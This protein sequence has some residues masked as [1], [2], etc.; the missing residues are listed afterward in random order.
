MNSSCAST[1]RSP[2]ARLCWTGFLLITPAVARTIPAAPEDQ[3]E[4]GVPPLVI[5][6]REAVGLSSEPTD[7]HL[8]S[9][10][11]LLV[12]GAAE[13]AIGD[14][15]RWEVIRAES[16]TPG[17]A[18]AT[19]AVDYEDRIYTGV[20]DGFA[21]VDFTPSGN[22]QLTRVADWPTELLGRMPVPRIV[23]NVAGRWFWH[24]QSGVV[25]EWRPGEEA[26]AFAQAST[27]EDIFTHNGIYYLSDRVVGRL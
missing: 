21:R 4:L 26:Q 10:G 19:V 18:F 22:W 2:L 11:R 27:T 1:D 24:A 8:L 16:E 14:G 5:M 25:L 6:S 12:M 3:L 9:D 13:I 7:L 17:N 15:V 20:P 23:Q